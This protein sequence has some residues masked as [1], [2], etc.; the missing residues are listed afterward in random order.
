M[1]SNQTILE[2]FAFHA[3]KRL[4]LNVDAAELLDYLG[5]LDTIYETHVITGAAYG[6][7]VLVKTYL[8]VRKNGHNIIEI[9]DLEV[10]W[11][12]NFTSGKNFTL[13]QCSGSVFTKG[14]RLSQVLDL[15]VFLKFRLLSQLSFVLKHIF[16][17]GD[18]AESKIIK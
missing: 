13:Q 15:N 12:K 9:P 2:V 7:I 1:T 8:Q 5:Q 16:T 14:L 17:K 10:T 4:N 11:K 6:S 3:Y 18:L